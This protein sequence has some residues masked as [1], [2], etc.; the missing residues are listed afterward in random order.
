MQRLPEVL[1]RNR[2]VIVLFTVLVI[3]PSLLLSY[4]GFRSVRADAV[5]Q[6][7]QQRNRQ[8]QIAFLLNGE[9]KSWLFSSGPDGAVSQA[10]IRF[11]IDGDR[12]SFPDSQLVVASET[13]KTPEPLGP[14][15]NEE[16]PNRR[17]IEEIYYPR[18]QFF[19]R[20]CKLG[21][22]PG[23]QYFRR[24]NSMIVQF[25]GMPNGY[26]LKSPKVVEFAQRKLDEMTSADDFQASLQ[27]DEPGEPALGGD[28]AVSLND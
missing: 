11:T 22:N 10:F 21:Q 12:I 25:P 15:K 17:E 2:T 4:V 20:D 26:V 13:Q 1:R 24:L 6:Q 8:R 16:A 3:V 5:Q 7:F 28:D 27:I 14:S 18:I 19:L 9:L 23:A